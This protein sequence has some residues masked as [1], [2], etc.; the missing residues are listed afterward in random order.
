MGDCASRPTK[1]D[2]ELH[3]SYQPK[4][5]DK[6]FHHRPEI[7]YLKDI[8]EVK[9]TTAELQERYQNFAKRLQDDMK[10]I[11]NIKSVEIDTIGHKP[12]YVAIE[13]FSAE[14]I[15]PDTLCIQ[16]A[17]PYVQT[18]IFPSKTWVKTDPSDPYLP[19]YNR[20]FTLETDG[21]SF[22]S[23]V[24]T[25][26]HERR[27][28]GPLEYGKVSLPFADFRDQEVKAGWYDLAGVPPAT[29]KTQGKPRIQLRMQF[30]SNL[31]GL[32]SLHQKIA[33]DTLAEAEKAFRLC[34]RLLSSIVVPP[35]GR[36]A[37]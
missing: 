1:E 29:D 12:A 36:G 24:F 21:P 8:V 14:N 2:L 5:F 27:F 20:Y 10:R 13:I 16:G 25:V 23:L 28:G 26:L 4:K 15:F 7:P 19:K 34:Q 22:E 31:S 33:E 35:E 9:I 6:N 32:L 11:N 30:I 17:R 37:T 3:H 18:Q